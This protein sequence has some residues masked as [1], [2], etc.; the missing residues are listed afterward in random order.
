MQQL[1]DLQR[2]T[3]EFIRAFVRTNGFAPSRPEIAQGLDIKHKSGIDSRLY[4]LERKGWIELRPGSPRFIRILDDDLPLI[5]AG[6]V[7]A[8]E[9]IVAE[10]R[11]QHRIPR[12]V[13]ECFRR[14]PDFFLRVEGD[15]MDR[16]GFMTG[17]VVAVK[18]QSDAENGEVIVARLEE[19]ITL[20]RYFRLDER[21]VELRPESTNSEHQPIE[22]DLETQ[23]FEIAGIAVGALIGDGFNG[24]EHENW[25]A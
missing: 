5:V 15:S 10:E 18:S 2:N 11:I 3:L 4:A 17:S 22:V 13:A 7:A 23:A 20:K 25:A 21:R 8:G 6:S 19:E 24:P 12:S 16:L 9:P 1:T 14:Q